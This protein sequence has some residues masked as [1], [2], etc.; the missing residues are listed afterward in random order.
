MYFI[1]FYLEYYLFIHFIY[2][3]ETCLE[4]WKYKVKYEY[5]IAWILYA[6]FK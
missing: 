3:I 2:T 6:L 4:K 1:V 5:Y